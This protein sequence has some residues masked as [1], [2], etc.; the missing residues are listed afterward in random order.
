MQSADAKM[1]E[2]CSQDYDKPYGD[3][4]D[5]EEDDEVIA[6]FDICLAGS[7]R[8]QLQLLQYPLRPSNRQYGDQGTLKDVQVQIETRA[9]FAA[10]D[11]AANTA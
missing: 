8:E 3:T 7:L 1:R 2:E 4:E 10:Q 5:D 11:A 6:E 9:V